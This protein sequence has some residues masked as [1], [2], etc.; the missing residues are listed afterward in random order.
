LAII[1]GWLA[2]ILIN[3]LADVM[4]RTRRMSAPFCLSCGK[5]LEPAAYFFW[6]RRCPDCG[7]LRSIRTWVVE[8]IF[9]AITVWI[10]LVPPPGITAPLGWI[11]LI[12]FGVVVIIDIE[13][14]LILHPTSAAGAV[15]GLAAGVWMHGWLLT[16]LGGL[17]GF[18]MT[19]LA[20][21]AGILLMRLVR[22]RSGG[23][24]EEEALGFGD[25]ILSGV[26]GLILGWPNVVIGLILAVFLGGAGSLVYMA[27][28]FLRRKFSGFMAIPY[29]PF[30]IGGTVLLLFFTDLVARLM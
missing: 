4:P 29:G 1:L 8:L 22:K 9:I 18:G 14:H 15:L 6:P 25:V 28:M 30:L 5:R 17:V 21:A 27:V 26:I 24:V 7:A 20:Y 10:W 23:P 13:H 11:L 16:L 19:F 2:G 3:Y 12:Y